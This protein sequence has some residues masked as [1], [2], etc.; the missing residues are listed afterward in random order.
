VNGVVRQERSIGL[1]RALST[2]AIACLLAAAPAA[3]HDARVSLSVDAAAPTGAKVNRNLVGVNWHGNLAH[4]MRPLG[5]DLVRQDASLERLFP[6][7]PEID[8]SAMRE[9]QAGV[10]RVVRAGGRPI[11]ILSYMPAWLADTREGDF[12]DRTKL[13]PRD[14]EV[15]RSL[16]E[17]V[18]TELTA[19]RRASGRRPVR[20]FEVWNEPDW[21]VFWQDRQDRFFEDVFVPSAQAVAE[22]ERKVGFDL[23]FGGCACVAPDAGWI[24]PM[25]ALARERDLPL[26]FVSWHWYANH[27]LLGPDGREPIGSPEQQAVVDLVFP[28]WGQRNPAATPL[29]YGEQISMVREW[30]SGA[31][32][33]SGRPMPELYIDEWNLAAGGFDG[34]MDT[35]DGAAFQAAVLT[36]MQRAGLDRASVYSGVD[37][38]YFAEERVNPSGE[39][40]HGGWGLVTI[41]GSR[42]P[43]WWPHWLWG[44]LAPEVVGAELDTAPADG[45]WALAS[46]ARGRATVMVSS[47]LAEGAHPHAASLELSGLKRG[48]WKLLVRRIDSSHRRAGVTARRRVAV[49]RASGLALELELPAQSIVFVELARR[50]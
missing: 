18:A 48:N 9:L 21:P 11:V 3:A 33:G 49:G 27:P 32:A 30:V 22:V 28:F 6:K 2:L 8:P 10:D 1:S 15:W 47:F 34:R 17:R 4:R 24:V 7:G 12:R 16:V 26:D 40:Y 31:L 41:R 44:R 39:E 20:R 35:N 46:R 37:P 14:R 25:V 29:S 45:V 23:R 38:A 36:E 43:A 13:P 50:R 42:K 19:G 5:I